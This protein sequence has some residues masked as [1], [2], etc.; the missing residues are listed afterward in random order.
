MGS[1]QLR[2]DHGVVTCS[3][4]CVN[5]DTKW[6][7]INKKTG[8]VSNYC[9]IRC[10]DSHISASRGHGTERKKSTTLCKTC[11]KYPVWVHPFT[12]VSSAFCSITCRGVTKAPEK[13]ALATMCKKCNKYPVFVHPKTGVPSLYCT[14]TCRDNQ[15]ICALDGC[16]KPFTHGFACCSPEHSRQHSINQ[17]AKQDPANYCQRAGCGKFVF[18]DPLGNKAG[19]CSDYCFELSAAPSWPRASYLRPSVLPVKKCAL[20]G[21]DNTAPAK[22]PCCSRE[23]GFRHSF[24]PV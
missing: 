13:K 17:K 11:Q 23:H 22:F 6:L 20:P 12:G 10:R 18:V 3:M 15:K 8:Q 19:F 1:Y 14:K 4:L 21:C 24:L 2:W 9:S 16:F 5:C 7:H